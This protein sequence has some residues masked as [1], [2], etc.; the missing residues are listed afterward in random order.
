MSE[1]AIEV[2]N[3]TKT[4]EINKRQSIFQ[5][6][7]N[8]KSKLK[9]IKALDDVSFSVRKGEVLGVIGWN[10]SGKTTLLQIIGGI[11]QPDSGVVNVEGTMAP[12]L[13]IST[14]FHPELEPE[15]NIILFGM[16][17]GFSKNKIKKRVESILQFAELEKFSTMKLKHFSTG[18]KSR[19]GISTIFQLNPDILLLDEILAV[20]DINFREKCYQSFT[21][22]KEQKKTIL[23]VT[24]SLDTVPKLCDRA[25][26]LHQ[27][28]LLMMGNPKDVIEKYKTL[29]NPKE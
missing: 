3:I 15:E 16:L 19:L 24:H 5:T 8:T 4:F 23:Y 22:F 6:I 14:G 18:M 9:I 20:G 27:G 17:L 12:I 26:L 2:S 28:K 10:G 29:K 7:R 21:S 25:I 13:R 11:Y 1:N